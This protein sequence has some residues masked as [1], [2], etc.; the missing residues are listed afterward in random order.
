MVREAEQDRLHLLAHSAS[1]STGTTLTAPET[2]RYDD[3]HLG[4]QLQDIEGLHIGTQNTNT[5]SLSPSPYTSRWDQDSEQEGNDAESF[6]GFRRQVPEQTPNHVG[7]FAHKTQAAAKK[8]SKGFLRFILRS[9][10]YASHIS[11]EQA[12]LDPSGKPSKYSGWRGGV[13]LAATSAGAVLCINLLFAIWAGA[14]SRSGMHVGT[15]YEG[16]CGVVHRTDSWI[17]IAINVMGTLLLGASNYTMQCLSAPTRSEID[18]A[19][20]IGRY[21]DIGLPSL[22]NLH[23]WKKRILFSAL[24][25]STLPLHFLWNSAVFTTTQR[26]DYNIY[27][28]APDFLANSTVDCSQNVTKSFTSVPSDY[29]TNMPLNGTY[30]STYSNRSES[31]GIWWLQD[32]CDI[33]K[34]LRANFSKNDLVQLDNEAC[35]KAYGPGNG[36]LAGYANLL[37][38]TREQPTGSNNTILMAFKYESF[39]SNYTGERWVCGPQY[40]IDNNYVCNYR[41]LAEDSTKWSL[42]LIESAP[43]NEYRLGAS[44]EWAI[45][46]CLAQPTDLTGH[47]LL[48][49]SLVIMLCVLAANSIKLI[50]IVCVLATNLDKVL[51]TIGDAIASFLEIPDPVT[52]GRPF[53]SRSQALDFNI[54]DGGRPQPYQPVQ[55]RWWQAPTWKRWLITLLL[56][57]FAIA[58]V[59]KLLTFGNDSLLANANGEYLSPYDVGF[60]TYSEYA[61]VNI[62]GFGS[63]T[64]TAEMFDSNR[65]LINMVAIANLPQVIVSCLYFA[66]NTVYTSMVSADEWARFAVHRKALRTTEPQGQQRSTYWLSL[67]WTYALPLASASSLLHWLISQSLFVSRTEVLNTRGEPEELSYMNVG[68]NPLAI[69]LAL[70]FGVA[71]LLAMLANGWR[72]LTH[73]SV[74]VGNNSLAIAAAC[75]RGAEQGAERGRV[76]W[77]AVRHEGEDGTPGHCC[78]SSGKVE[79]PRYMD[80]YL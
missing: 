73:G 47:C 24:V 49:Y 80:K 51:A 58:V 14:T 57:L 78:F 12:N 45:D 48:Q 52:I 29:D 4:Y 75:Q 22:R 5:R 7:T 40:L 44:D 32:M 65:I 54:A 64:I 18:A 59:G 30:W 11:Y 76:M 74:L 9:G 37:A 70:L 13:L 62:F 23:G 61:V 28:V 19:H 77:G 27:V 55:L 8:W 15:I 71:L 42:G 1:I 63:A 46:Y 39:V 69:L 66:M 6:D 53:L 41:K 10:R 31:S 43:D 67:P 25:V 68:Y 34:D 56:C 38:V 50:C 60:G 72:R 3:P 36:L 21:M 2:H 33:S 17:H 35:I 20:C 26:L 16:D 79:K